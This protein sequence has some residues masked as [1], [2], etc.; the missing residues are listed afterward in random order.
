VFKLQQRKTYIKIRMIA[1]TLMLTFLVPI[2]PV[3]A[4]PATRERH[5]QLEQ[6]LREAR[7]EVRSQQNL[8]SGTRHEMSQ[9]MAEMQE[10][11][12]KMMDA[13]SALESITLSLLDTE[14]RI[15]DAEEALETAREDYDFQFEALRT[16][17]RVMHEQGSIGF[18]DV[19]FQAESISDFFAR[20]E[21]IRVVAQYDQDL[22]ERIRQT[23]SRI[24]SNLE[25]L[26]RFRNLVEDLS[27]QYSR[28]LEDLEFMM[29]ERGE[30]FA[31]L[32]ENEEALAELLAIAEHEQGMAELAFGEIQTQLNREITELARQRAAQEHNERL[33][34]LNNFDGRFQWPIP[35]HSRVSSGFGMRMHP[36][37]RQNRMHT[38]IDVGAPTGTRLIAA[39][40]GVVRFA[41][42]SGGYGNTVIIDHGNG[43]STL[44][45]HNSRNRVTT[46]QRVERGQHIADVGSTGMSTGPHLHFEIRVNNVARDPEDYFPR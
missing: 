10:L 20:W 18:I 5:R 4:S 23:E 19:L 37:L 43:Y 14:I 32:A 9:I 25:D 44:Y 36:I 33:A 31:R 38:G 29:E 13:A 34:R 8:L 45:A 7:Q 35:T 15:A 21:Y 17:I 28:V 30:W 40:D 6:Q 24:T 41:G 22:L 2:L 27:F 3:G 16:R 39:A 46:G 1:F 26:S 11:D 12:Q 42:W